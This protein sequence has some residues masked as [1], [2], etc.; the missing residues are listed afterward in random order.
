MEVHRNA[1]AKFDLEEFLARPLLAHLA[2]LSEDGARNSLFWYLWENDAIWIILEEGFNTVQERIRSDPRV[3]VGFADFDPE[4]GF[5]QHVSIRGT[6]SLETWDDDRAG[7][8][9]HRYYCQLQDYREAAPHVGEKVHG[10][11]PM[12]F[13]RIHPES[14]FLREHSY[15]AKVLGK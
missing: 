6:A 14:V 2:S 8:L 1:E 10:R 11:L 5:L 12:T 3:A 4:R 7:R 9:L 15:G 13:L